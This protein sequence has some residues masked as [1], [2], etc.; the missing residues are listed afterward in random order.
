MQ[1]I[2]TRFDAKLRHLSTKDKLISSISVS[3]Y[4][5]VVLAPEMAVMLVKEDMGVD[6]EAARALLKESAALGN[7]LNEEEDQEI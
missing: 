1:N 2:I 7:L 4:V 6:D 5:Q 3:S